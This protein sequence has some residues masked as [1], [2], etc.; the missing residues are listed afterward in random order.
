MAKF[1]QFLRNCRNCVEHPKHNQQVVFTNFTMTPN[2]EIEPPTIEIVHEQTPEPVVPLTIFMDNMVGSV[3][4]LGEQTM[5]FLASY[6]VMPGWEE[7]VSDISKR[8]RDVIRMC[9]IILR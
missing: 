1:A 8:V 3:V 6:H 5:A 2:A 7:T 4:N 9:D